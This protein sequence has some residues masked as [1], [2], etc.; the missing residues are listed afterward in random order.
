[1]HEMSIAHS[2]IDLV[3]QEMEKY[4]GAKLVGFDIEVGEFSRVQDQALTFCLGACLNETLW[5]D[6]EIRITPEAVCARC[7]SCDR[8]FTPVDYTFICPDCDSGDVEV[9]CG[10]EVRLKSLE[11]DE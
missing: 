5:P 1:M 11:I 2:I 7:I 3:G 8:T 9:T 4:P 10:R 6:A